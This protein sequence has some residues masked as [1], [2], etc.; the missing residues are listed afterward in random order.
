MIEGNKKK[1]TSIISPEPK[2]V[3][4]YLFNPARRNPFFEL[5]HL[6]PPAQ[7]EEE[8]IEK[9]LTQILSKPLTIFPPIK[10]SPSPSTF[11]K[12]GPPRQKYNPLIYDEKFIEINSSASTQESWFSCTIN[13]IVN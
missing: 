2:R 13:N 4:T 10:K 7:G 11:A 9:E 8:S 12:S 1:S 5:P 3:N 6:K